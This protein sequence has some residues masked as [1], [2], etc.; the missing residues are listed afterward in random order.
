MQI[1]I[2]V[3]EKPDSW[4]QGV[5]VS[6]TAASSSVWTVTSCCC[7]ASHAV[8]LTTPDTNAVSIYTNQRAETLLPRLELRGEKEKPILGNCFRTSTRC[9]MAPLIWKELG[10]QNHS[11]LYETAAWPGLRKKQT[12][13]SF[14]FFCFFFPL[15]KQTQ[16]WGGNEM[17]KGFIVHTPQL[18]GSWHS[19]RY[20]SASSP[21]PWNSLYH[22]LYKVELC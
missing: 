7:S 14:L 15:K 8:L 6:S 10:E 4:C 17:R 2:L 5:W 9:S 16:H 1:I 19:S 22:I 3:W 21:E 11:W 18:L 13:V 12:S 20:S